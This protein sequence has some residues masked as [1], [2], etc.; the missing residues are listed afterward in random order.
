MGEGGQGIINEEG[1]YEYP[2][3]YYLELLVR[4]KGE[5]DAEEDEHGDPDPFYMENWTAQVQIMAA[6]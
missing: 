3:L 4:D 5:D 2:E 1:C 6:A